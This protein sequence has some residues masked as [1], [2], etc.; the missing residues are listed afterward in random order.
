MEA[1]NYDKARVEF[2]NALQI[3]ATD[4]D[5]R[6]DVGMVDEK[7]GKL[8]EAAQFYQAAID[9]NPD[10]LEART[11]LG[12]LMMFAGAPDRAM[13]Q[14]TAALAK[15]PEDSELLALRA[16]YHVQKKEQSEAR[17]DAE[18]AIR[19]DPKNEDAA[20]VL[21]GI[22]S[23]AG[24]TDR[25]LKLLE[26]TIARVP[27]SVDL[28]LTLAQ[29]YASM[30]RPADAERILTDLIKL[31]PGER[32]H[33]VR[34]AQYYNSLSQLDAAESTLREAIRA[35]P[36]DRLVKLALID[37][38]SARRTPQ[39]AETE[40][41]AM[42]AA[43][44]KDVELKFALANFYE[45]QRN[46]AAAEKI[47]RE[48]IE[49]EQLDAAGLS[50]RDRLAQLRVQQSDVPG[51]QKLIAEVLAKSPRDT[52]ALT[53]RG[54]IELAQKNPKAAIADLR[55][56]LRDQPNSVPI[57]RALARAH[58]ANGEPAIAI[59]TLQDAVEANPKDADSR[60]DLAQLL[61]Q[62]GK[63]EDAKPIISE[64][65]KDQPANPQ[66][67]D[68]MFRID[69][70]TQD[71]VGA[72]AAADGLVAAKPDGALGY[73]YQGM[74][75]QQDKR[76]DEALRLYAK[77]GDLQPDKIEP[78]EHEVRLLLSL[79]R[80]PEA[81]KRIDQLTASVP[82]APFAPS[83]KGDVL[84]GQ[85]RPGEAIEAYK[86]AITRAPTWWV[87][88]KGLA[89]AQMQTNDADGALE[90]LRKG[91]AKV[92]QPEPLMIETALV[93]ERLNRPDDA[94]RTY[95]EVLKRNSRSDVAANNLA[96]ML[97]TF[98]TDPA[99]LDR[100]KSLAARF[101]DSKNPSL[102]D[103]YGWVLYKHGEAAASVAVLEKVIAK[104][105]DEPVALYHLGMAQSQAGGN[106]QARKNLERAV[107]SG[108]KFPGLEEARARLTKLSS[109][110]ARTS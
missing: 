85:R 87:P 7:L 8:R 83:M 14:V 23:S 19:L 72:K 49:H 2:Q 33:R 56:V 27:S 45:S 88:Y 15:H 36:K 67:L 54:N 84:M 96:M 20:A 57:L 42:V 80:V 38:L 63:P 10:H 78:L 29:I 22:Y 58:L 97:V 1:G 108:Q 103:T 5:I 100:A 59:E 64:L 73:L 24:E 92:D 93:Y 106:E 28:R 41:K 101:A 104:Y 71:W 70:A 40:L 107:N 3:A 32:A 34:L 91:Q 99:S 55:A 110:E 13:E 79:K 69:A 60:L 109:G 4:A 21:A 16:A 6:Y 52:D 35:L 17:A 53:L 43:D 86:L 30:N 11:R 94:I 62:S 68:A 105:P 39:Q 31:Q 44:P 90:T 89:A 50:A 25:A 37:F 102:L 77:A 76:N 61:A 81:L 74:L 95:E 18:H 26:D 51:A 47:Y 98:K 46:P 82:A 75:A 66:A 12:R 48:V 9:V 65:V